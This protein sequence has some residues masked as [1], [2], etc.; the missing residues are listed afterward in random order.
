MYQSL[1]GKGKCLDGLARCKATGNNTIC[2][3]ADNFCAVNVEEVLDIVANRDEYDIRELMPDPFPYNFYFA[4][5]NTPK[6]QK[7]V[8]AYTNY[9]DYSATVGNAFGTTGD[10]GREAMT[11]EDVQ[12]LLKQGVYVVSYAGDAGM[13]LVSS[14]FGLGG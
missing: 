6:V 10:D 9:S 12:K 5:L 2:S 13:I 8:G 1:F 7:A 4:Y 11:I 3:N 14:L